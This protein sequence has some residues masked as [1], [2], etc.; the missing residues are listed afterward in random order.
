MSITDE[1][2]TA[3]AQL[4]EPAVAGPDLLPTRLAQACTRVLPIDGAGI[5]MF[6]APTMRIPIG[7]SGDDATIANDSKTPSL[8]VRASSAPHRATRSGHRTR[9][10]PTMADLPR[11]VDHPNPRSGGS[12]PSHCA[13]GSTGSVPTPVGNIL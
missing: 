12:S 13:A 10:R 8:R 5:S 3:Y 1:F 2:Q 4:R 7:A 6:T 9:H 11:P